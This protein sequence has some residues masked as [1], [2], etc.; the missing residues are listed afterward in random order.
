[1]LRKKIVSSWSRVRQ[2]V[3][4]LVSGEAVPA[5]SDRSRMAHWS[6]LN[7]LKQ[8]L[9]NHKQAR[10]K[11][12]QAGAGYSWALFAKEML[13]DPRSIGAACPSSPR[14]ARAMAAPLNREEEGLVI[15]LGGGTGTVTAALLAHGI[16][17]ERIISVERSAALAAHLRHRFPQLQVIEGDAMHLKSLL[18]KSPKKVSAVVSSLPLR[19]L[20]HHCVR[21]IMQQIDELLDH[22]GLLIQFTYDLSGRAFE[23]QHKHF[24]RVASHIIWHN[25]PPAR[26]DIFRRRSLAKTSV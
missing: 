9:H 5:G 14:L 11:S 4:K 22:N 10:N 6:G 23:H 19:S 17:P 25:L 3:T 18:G 8:H 12:A 1:M 24:V 13:S 2:S 16:A 20:P 21:G 15:E 26:V 7:A